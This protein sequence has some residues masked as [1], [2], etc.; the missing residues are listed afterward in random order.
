MPDA[1]YTQRVELLGRIAR[2][3]VRRAVRRDDQ[4]VLD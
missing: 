3:R 2:L 1:G 4:V